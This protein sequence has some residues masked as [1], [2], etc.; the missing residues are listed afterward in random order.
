MINRYAEILSIITPINNDIPND[1]FPFT[2]LKYILT[3]TNTTIDI[4]VIN[5]MVI[6]VNRT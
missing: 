3:Q 2:T 6:N 1:W 5:V 4:A